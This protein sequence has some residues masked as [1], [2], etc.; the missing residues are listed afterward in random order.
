[1]LESMFYRSKSSRIFLLS[2]RFLLVSLLVSACGDKKKDENHPQGACCG[3]QETIVTADLNNAVGMLILEN[4]GAA[5]LH[6]FK[7]VSLAE[8]DA[9]GDADD[10]SLVKINEDGEIEPAISIEEDEVMMGPPKQLPK[11]LTIAVS[12]HKDVYLHFERPFIYRVVDVPGE[13]PWD[14]S[15]GYQCQ[16]FKVEGG[17]LDKLLVTPPEA[18]NLE[19]IDNLRFIDSWQANRNSVFQFDDDSNVYYPASL[20]N[21]GGKMVVYKRTR[22]GETTTEVINSN[23]CVNDF[24]ITKNGGVFYTGSSSCEGGGGDAG[25][26]FRYV[27]PD[28]GG[29]REIARDWWNFVFEPKAGN[30]ATDSAVFFGPDPRSS[31]TASWNSACLFNF[32]PSAGTS[33]TE[34]ISDVITCGSDIWSWINVT[35]AEDIPTYGIGND[36]TNL[37]KKAL[38]VAELQNRCESEGQIFAGGGSQINA[39]KQDTLGNVYVIGKVRKKK[40]GEISCGLQIRGQHCVFDNAPYLVGDTTYGTEVLCQEAGGL[41]KGSTGFCDGFPEFTT[42]ADCEA[43]MHVWKFTSEGFHYN[44]VSTDLCTDLDNANREVN[45]WDISGPD[46]TAIEAGTKVVY[47]AN[48]YNCQPIDASSNGGDQWTDEYRALAIV[49][50]ETKTLS[51]LSGTNEQAVQI[52]LVD[53]VPYYSTYNTTDG[54]YYLKRYSVTSESSAVLHTNFEAYNIASGGSSASVYYDGLDFSNNSYSFGTMSTSA[55]YDRTEKTGLTGTVKTIVILP[56]D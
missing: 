29:V 38:W 56:Q 46:V 37:T 43:A 16:I 32:D 21:G 30:N 3:T 12:P 36:E 15:K 42:E 55:P 40:A 25:G 20:P 35:R 51:M 54:K 1:M 47:N 50:E 13:D 14:M 5:S 39:I 18:D 24:L 52:W 53:D 17:T 28:D 7:N 9:E 27:A 8:G 19:C 6:G 23:I 26:F 33:A 10:S 45:I 48:W 2:M 31:T 49:D 44:N 41:W 11:I 34:S 4:N 22:D